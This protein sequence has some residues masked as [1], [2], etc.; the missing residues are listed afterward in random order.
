M[1]RETIRRLAYG[2]ARCTLVL[3]S[4]WLAVP[5]S[6]HA[7][8]SSMKSSSGMVATLG[9]YR[10]GQSH[11]PNESQYVGLTL[12][13]AGGKA[14]ASGMTVR[15]LAKNG[16][17]LRDTLDLGFHRVNFWLNHGQVIQ[18]QRF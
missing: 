8:S 14:R 6:A 13:K 9:C 17:C 16:H 12:T 1:A 3:M 15:I 2:L 11:Y 5:A 10:D 4:G 7:L 18:A